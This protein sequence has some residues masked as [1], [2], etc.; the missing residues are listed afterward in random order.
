M[1]RSQGG[2]LCIGLS[3][4]FGRPSLHGGLV[5]CLHALH[6]LLNR[7]QLLLVLLEQLLQSSAAIVFDAVEGLVMRSTELR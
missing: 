4:S 3:L 6:L 7:P 1:F 2:Q 5:R